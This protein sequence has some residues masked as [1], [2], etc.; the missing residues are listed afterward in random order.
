MQF[1]LPGIPPPQSRAPVRRSIAQQIDAIWLN[2]DGIYEL[3]SI[4]D[5]EQALYD[6]LDAIVENAESHRIGAPRTIRKEDGHLKEFRIAMAVR[7]PRTNRQFPGNDFNE[8]MKGAYD[9]DLFNQP[10]DMLI[11]DCIF[12]IGRWMEKSRPRRLTDARPSIGSATARRT[13]LL[14]FITMKRQPQNYY[15]YPKMKIEISKGLN[16]AANT[17]WGGIP[18]PGQ[19]NGNSYFG[20]FELRQ[21]LDWELEYASSPRFSQQHALAWVLSCLNGVRPCSL[22][23]L[24]D[25]PGEYLRWRDIEITRVFEGQD[26]G[27]HIGRFDCAIG[28]VYLKTDRSINVDKGTEVNR[29]KLK[30]Y[31]RH[32]KLVQN[33]MFS[34]ALRFLAIMLQ[35]GILDGIETIDELLTSSTSAPRKISIKTEYLDKPIFLAGKPGGRGYN[36]DGRP[37]ST[38]GLSGYFKTRALAAGYTETTTFYAWRKGAGVRVDRIKGRSRARAFLGHSPGDFTFETYYDDALV[39]LDITA[40]ALNEEEE[41]VES[42]T[43]ACLHRICYNLSREDEEKFVNTFIQYDERYIQATTSAERKNASRCARLRARH[44]LRAHM[45]AEYEKLHSMDEYAARVK[46]LT[47]SGKLFEEVLA[48]AKLL[49]AGDEDEDAPEDD[50]DNVDL[51]DDLGIDFGDEAG[52]ESLSLGNAE[53]GEQDDVMISEIFVDGKKSSE[54]NVSDNVTYE[55]FVRAFLEK[56]MEEDPVTLRPTLGTAARK[57]PDSKGYTCGL[58][59]QDKTTSVEEKEKLWESLSRLER[60]QVSGFH[61]GNKRFSRRMKMLNP[62]ETDFKCPYPSCPKGEHTTYRTLQDLKLHIIRDARALGRSQH[63]MSIRADHWLEDD[64]STGAETGKNHYRKRKYDEFRKDDEFEESLSVSKVVKEADGTVSLLAGPNP[65][66][67]ETSRS[68]LLLYGLN[69]VPCE[70][71]LLKGEDGMNDFAKFLEGMRNNKMFISGSN[72]P[73]RP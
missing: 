30:Q 5:E 47:N 69:P 57:I 55:F 71:S 12:M 1:T 8:Y 49:A 6:R 10:Q 40:I 62:R 41:A 45:R 34:P 31:S 72:K 53:D 58:C 14:K 18:I 54:S 29:R 42:T 16:L 35:R 22:A 2:S 37:L 23:Q 46:A 70:M 36:E 48:R 66:P 38:N 59:E 9:S 64:F 20:K 50:E 52:D 13:T 19:E 3:T 51:S 39:D 67:C 11:K 4:T 17:I 60:H 21:L 73:F 28:Y 65:V 7:Y 43:Q 33:I 61:N 44:A 26:G 32:P 56:L 63:Q 24:S 15:S 25:R 68:P 27:N